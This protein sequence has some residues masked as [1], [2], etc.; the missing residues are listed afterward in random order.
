M[1]R[2]I[3]LYS[4]VHWTNWKKDYIVQFTQSVTVK[5]A[6]VSLDVKHSSLIREHVTTQITAALLTHL[7]ASKIFLL[8]LK[9]TLCSYTMFSCDSTHGN[10]L[11]A[12]WYLV[13][14]WPILHT[15]TNPYVRNSSFRYYVTY[16]D[17]AGPCLA[18]SPSAKSIKMSPV[19]L[20]GRQMAQPPDHRWHHTTH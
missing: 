13:Q 19:R 17:M 9:S 3:P 18:D 6:T 1:G 4:T 20:V 16:W 14:Q 5:L 10:L 11:V 2:K 15:T 12:G 8:S 7:A